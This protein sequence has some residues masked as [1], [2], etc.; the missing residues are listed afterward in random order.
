MVYVLHA[1]ILVVVAL[2]LRSVALAPMLKFALASFI[3]IPICFV[4]GGLAR[5]LPMA[6]RIL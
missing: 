1:P 4:T 3:S 2:G 6:E 5:R